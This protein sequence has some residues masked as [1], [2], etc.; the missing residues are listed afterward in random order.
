[1]NVAWLE[2]PYDEWT[3]DEISQTPTRQLAMACQ[4][5]LFARAGRQDEWEREIRPILW[6]DLMPAGAR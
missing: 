2:K 1:M 5:D 3:A 6:P 4:R